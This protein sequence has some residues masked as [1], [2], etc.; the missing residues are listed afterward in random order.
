M[1]KMAD[2]IS[3]LSALLNSPPAGWSAQRRIEY[4]EW[5]REVVAGCRS[6]IMGLSAIFDQL[7]ERRD[8]ES[9]AIA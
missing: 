4:F 1:L 6:A 3:N 5:A 9:R 8:R 7:Y 2:K